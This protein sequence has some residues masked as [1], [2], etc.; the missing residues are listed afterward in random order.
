MKDYF[1]EFWEW[2]DTWEYNLWLWKLNKKN[3]KT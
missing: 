2:F 1:K 3:D